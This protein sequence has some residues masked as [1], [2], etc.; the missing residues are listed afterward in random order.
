MSG[1]AVLRHR[2]GAASVSG[3]ELKV[4]IEPHELI[5]RRPEFP[6]RRTRP[7]DHSNPGAAALKVLD[8]QDVISVASNKDGH[9]VR[10]PRLHVLVRVGQQAS[11]E[12]RIELLLLFAAL[13]S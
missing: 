10:Q 5:R 2:D 7:E 6:A 4:L 13:R 8:R 9:H 11:R 3:Q 12:V 1:L